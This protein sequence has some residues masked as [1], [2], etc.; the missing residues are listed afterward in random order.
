MVHQGTLYIGA[1]DG[2]V[3]AI[4]LT[5][6]K[7][8]NRWNHSDE[9][10]KANWFINGSI[11]LRRDEEVVAT[12]GDGT[13]FGFSLDGEPIW[14]WSVSGKAVAS[15]QS[16]ANGFVYQ[17]LICSQDAKSKKPPGRLC[18]YDPDAGR[19]RWRFDCPNP[20]E[21]TAA[22][23]GE[24]NVYVGDNAGVLYSVDRGGQERWR[25]ELGSPI[26]SQL[27]LHPTGGTLLVI[28]DNARLS[29]IDVAGM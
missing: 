11:L 9:H 28:S 2:F 6:S 3:Y 20:I 14:S 7:G 29:A 26:R 17:G 8:R 19:E 4:D 5:G 12:G 1:E 13:I 23:D 24:G 18:C 10:G 16:C 25:I 22:I 27:A 21:S 15:A